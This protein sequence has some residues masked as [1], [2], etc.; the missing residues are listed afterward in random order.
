MKVFA[1]CF[2]L[3]FLL[4]VDL[5]RAQILI[6][7]S[8]A[9]TGSTSDSNNQKCEEKCEEKYT[10]V[11]KSFKTHFLIY[12]ALL[13]TIGQ[14]LALISLLSRAYDATRCF[15]I[16]LLKNRPSIIVHVHESSYGFNLV[17]KLLFIYN[18]AS[19]CSISTNIYL[20]K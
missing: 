12:C 13:I 8:R 18:Q 5:N 10:E 7:T 4:F 16:F 17:T 2:L 15:N 3:C 11:I 19:F 20:G 14:G 6:Q 9:S 1:P